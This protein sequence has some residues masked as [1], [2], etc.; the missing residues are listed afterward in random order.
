M[1]SQRAGHLALRPA[2]LVDDPRERRRA[3]RP[4]GGVWR[5][6]RI[7]RHAGT[8]RAP[9]AAGAQGL[10]LKTV[11]RLKRILTLRPTP[12]DR[13]S[14]LPLRPYHSFVRSDRRAGF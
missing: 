6:W 12:S 13:S 11:T 3:G 14:L 5:F 1:V 4:D 8:R 2:V 10:R 9:T 7:S